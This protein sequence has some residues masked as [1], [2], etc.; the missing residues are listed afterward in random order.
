MSTPSDQDTGRQRVGWL[1]RH[2]ITN[3][4]ALGMMLLTFSNGVDQWSRTVG[5]LMTLT[6]MI[7]FLRILWGR[8]WRPTPAASTEDDSVPCGFANDGPLCD[9]GEP[10][11]G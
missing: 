4:W 7:L 2:Q 1:D 10:D 6:A 11:R 5:G 3:G 8:V 9:C